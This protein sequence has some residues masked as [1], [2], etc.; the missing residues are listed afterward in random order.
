MSSP[1][2]CL[3]GVVA[4]SGVSGPIAGRYNTFLPM[5]LRRAQ[6]C[7]RSCLA[8]VCDHGYALRTYPMVGAVVASHSPTNA[9]GW[10]LCVVGLATAVANFTDV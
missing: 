9:V 8:G 4:C 5:L 1:H 7:G 10:L 2:R 6:L 3:A